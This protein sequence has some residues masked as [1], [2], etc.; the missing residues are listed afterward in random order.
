MNVRAHVYL[1]R[2]MCCTPYALSPPPCT[3]ETRA[4]YEYSCMRMKESH[5]RTCRKQRN[6]DAKTVPAFNAECVR[7]YARACPCVEGE[8]ATYV[9]GRPLNTVAGNETSSFPYR[10]RDLR[11]GF[12]ERADPE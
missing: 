8:D 9:S 6:A 1:Y 7:A 2:G 3:T 4:P 11:M 12:R 10:N 5:T